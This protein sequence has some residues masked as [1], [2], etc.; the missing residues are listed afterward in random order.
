MNIPDSQSFTIAGVDGCKAAGLSLSF[1]LQRRQQRIAVPAHNR[2][3]R[4]PPLCRCAS[5]DKPVCVRVRE[6]SY[7]RAT[8]GTRACDWLPQAVIRQAATLPEHPA[9][10]RKAFMEILDPACNDTVKY[11]FRQ[12]AASR[13]EALAMAASHP[14]RPSP[15]ARR[16]HHGLVLATA[17]IWSCPV[18]S[19]LSSCNSSVLCWNRGER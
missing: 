5:E 18:S 2:V 4:C 10:D 11:F 9:N 15:A 7:R 6:I 12:V 14:R 17:P 3:F 1:G 13:P 19:Q 8:G 16:C